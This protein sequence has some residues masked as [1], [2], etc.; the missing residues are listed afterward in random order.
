MSTTFLYYT[1]SGKIYKWQTSNMTGVNGTADPLHRS[2]MLPLFPLAQLKFSPYL[3][4][5][6]KL[7]P[8]IRTQC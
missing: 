6:H 2:A 1:Q 4:T 3:L 8:T 5:L 7:S